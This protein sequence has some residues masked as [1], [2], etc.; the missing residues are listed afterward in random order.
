MRFLK[1]LLRGDGSILLGIHERVA[2]RLRRQFTRNISGQWASLTIRNPKFA[3]PKEQEQGTRP[4]SI[5]RAFLARKWRAACLAVDVAVLTS[6]SSARIEDR[7]WLP[8]LRRQA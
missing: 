4:A 3:Y 1:Q 2:V 6:C 8:K 7:Q 5:C